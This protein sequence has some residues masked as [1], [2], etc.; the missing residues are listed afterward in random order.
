MP[1]GPVTELANA[2]HPA[3]V[4]CLIPKSGWKPYVTFRVK[5]LRGLFLY[6][7]CRICPV[8]IGSPLF[9]QSGCKGLWAIL[10]R[11]S[12]A[13]RHNIPAPVSCIILIR[14]YN[15]FGFKES[16]FVWRPLTAKPF[17]LLCLQA[18]SYVSFSLGRDL[19][20]F[21]N[22]TSRCVSKANEAYVFLRKIKRLTETFWA[23][24]NHQRK[25]LKDHTLGIIEEWELSING[26]SGKRR[27]TEEVLLEHRYMGLLVRSRDFLCQWYKKQHPPHLF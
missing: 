4:A 15:L 9:P 21:S 7:W 1:L 24:N 13:T 22:A 25:L 5:F 2:N 8:F 23:L 12:Y 20:A 27:Q 19:S 10:F 3:T 16:S 17:L 6:P 11:C 18:N 14:N 26:T